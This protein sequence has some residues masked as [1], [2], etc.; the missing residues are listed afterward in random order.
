[1]GNIEKTALS[2]HLSGSAVLFLCI[3]QGNREKEGG[4]LP[5]FGA[6]PH[7]LMQTFHDFIGNG[8]TQTASGGIVH[9]GFIKAFKNMGQIFFCDTASV[10]R[11]TDGCLGIFGGGTDG[12]GA[13]IRHKFDGIV[14]Q[15]GN[16]LGYAFRIGTEAAASRWCHQSGR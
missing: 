12:N 9:G 16:Q 7:F 1:M 3:A 6:Y 10:V 2:E 5:G 15:N 4:T 13:V 8:K 11:D 14:Q